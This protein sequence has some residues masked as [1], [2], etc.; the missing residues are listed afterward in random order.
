MS[1]YLGGSAK[2]KE[3]FLK[4]SSSCSGDH[5]L[6]NLLASDTAGDLSKSA[7]AMKEGGNKKTV[8]KFCATRWTARV[9]TLV[10]LLSKYV[11]VLKAL[12]NIRDSSTA[13]AR[14]DASSYIRLMEDSQF[15]VALTVTQFV[16]SFLGTVITTLQSTECNL[17][18]A[19]HDVALARE[20][21]RDSR[22]EEYWKKLWATRVLQIA[23]AVGI[24][25][26]KPRS[27]GQQLHRANA[28]AVDQSPS[29][30]YRINVTMS[31]ILS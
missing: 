18:A 16:L 20:C 6:L 28:G 23:S 31:T 11:V 25:I 9:S 24:S 10:S 4:V 21:I 19:Y 3:I 12:E 27:V 8:P 26:S 13:E 15:I 30:Y 29:D 5:H 1:W 22:N 7:E 14:S 17:A 2:R